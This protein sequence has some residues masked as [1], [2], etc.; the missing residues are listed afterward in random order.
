MNADSIKDAIAAA[1][2]C[3]HLEVKGDGQHWY[4]TIVS[5]AF[6]GQRA[7]ARHR[8]VYAAVGEHLQSE[9]LHA[10]SMQTYTPAEYAKVTNS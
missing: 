3:E 6:E 5:A 7:L 9:A 4:A 2:P 1:L 10:L 8:Q